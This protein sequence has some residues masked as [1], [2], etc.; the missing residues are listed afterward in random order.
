MVYKKWIHLA[1][2]FWI[3]KNHKL[4]CF[5]L[6]VIIVMVYINGVI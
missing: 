3:Q 2:Y 6:I 4:E 5:N 1:V